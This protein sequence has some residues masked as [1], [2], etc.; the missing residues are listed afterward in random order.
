MVVAE[1]SPHGKHQH[2]SRNARP[3][4]SSIGRTAVG[5]ALLL[6]ALL[7]LF[8]NM[9]VSTTGYRRDHLAT[10]ICE[11]VGVEPG[12]VRCGAVSIA[13]W[14]AFVVT[15]GVVLKVG[16]VGL[17]AAGFGRGKR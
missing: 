15:L 3:R 17:K 5:A 11:S 14:F 16:R 7:L 10:F 2:A 6:G 9:P 4:H 8:S 12:T 13:G 1:W